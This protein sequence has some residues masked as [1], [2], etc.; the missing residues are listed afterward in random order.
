MTKFL[1]ISLLLTFM[2]CGKKE[3]PQGMTRVLFKTGDD[4]AI[5][6]YSLNKGLVV[7]GMNMDQFKGAAGWGSNIGNFISSN[8][9]VILPNGKYRFF[10]VGYDDN[11]TPGNDAFHTS[12]KL[13]CG[14]GNG[15]QEINLVGGTVSVAITL[16]YAA[17]GS[18]CAEPFSGPEFRTNSPFSNSF[19]TLNITFC[20][21]SGVTNSGCASSTAAGITSAEIKVTAYDKIKSN[22][23][24]DFARSISGCKTLSLGNI[25][26]ESKIP[27]RMPFH[28]QVK[29]WS[30]ASCT[31][32]V[33]GIFDF[34]N[35]VEGTTNNPNMGLNNAAGAVTIYVKQ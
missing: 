8:S 30:G 14:E 35:G 1:F 18:N 26:L 17:A 28:F 32:S 11:G 33:V 31:G 10:A 23:D 9:E 15:G 5:T 20:N 7:Y 13:F 3:V 2:A 12:S 29:A 21:S 27:Y 16:V 22:L 34:P 24:F 4:K 25:N 19:K 6:A